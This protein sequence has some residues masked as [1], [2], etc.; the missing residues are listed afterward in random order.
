MTF[1]IR[2]RGD[3]TRPVLAVYTCEE[4]GPFDAEVQREPNGDTPDEVPCV[5]CSAPATWTPSAVMGKVKAWEVVRGKYEKPERPTYLDTRELG[6]GQSYDDFKAK[7]AK[8]WDEKRWR[9]TKE[10]L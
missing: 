2:I 1:T 3:S 9:E 8:V 7:R 6:E 5:E 10:L 4:H